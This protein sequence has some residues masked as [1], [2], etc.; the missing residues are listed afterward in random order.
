MFSNGFPFIN[1][2][3]VN[4]VLDIIPH[5]TYGYA[6]TRVIDGNDVVFFMEQ[7]K[8]SIPRRFYAV[9]IN[10]SLLSKLNFTERMILHCIYSRSCNG[11]VREKHIKA[12]LSEDFPDWTIPYIVK[13]CDEYVIEILYIVYENLKDRDTDKIKRF[14]ADNW[15]EFCK[16]Y[17]RMI[18]YWNVYYRNECRKYEN[19]IGRKL[20]VECFGAKQKMNFAE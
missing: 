3:V 19:Y 11:F 12:L 9:E 4:R 15:N 18:S 2:D 16:S 20:F 7:V 6:K 13:I 5:K 8:I 1:S 14:C 10:D 17:S